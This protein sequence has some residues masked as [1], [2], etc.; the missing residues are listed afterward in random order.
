MTRP[1][2]DDESTSVYDADAAPGRRARRESIQQFTPTDITS[3]RSEPIRVISMKNPAELEPKLAVKLP[4]V[5]L[6]SLTD[7]TPVPKP[8]SSLGHL[9]PPRDPKAVRAR[10]LRDYLIWGS[11]VVMLSCAV[12]L[13]IWFLARR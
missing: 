1:T 7:V 12:T 13:A 11:V 9:A 2:T 3:N 8:S 10:R 4:V 5:K 6:R